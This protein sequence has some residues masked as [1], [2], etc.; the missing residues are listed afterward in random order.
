MGA[1]YSIKVVSDRVLLVLSGAEGIIVL[2]I[3]AALPRLAGAELVLAKASL[4][5]VVPIS[6]FDVLIFACIML[7]KYPAVFVPLLAVL[8][9][10]VLTDMLLLF[11]V[12][13]V[14]GTSVEVVLAATVLVLGTTAFELIIALIG[15]VIV[16]LSDPKLVLGTVELIVASMPTAV[17]GLELAD[18]VLVFEVSACAAVVALNP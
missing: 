10:R 2:V 1:T 7:V 3:G 11:E 8:A 15:V 4:M 12:T 13:A 5:V 16:E 14:V 6:V 18:S 9:S 17:V